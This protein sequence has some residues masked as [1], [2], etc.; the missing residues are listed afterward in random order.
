MFVS[1]TVENHHLAEGGDTIRHGGPG[2]NLGQAIEII[3]P[4]PHT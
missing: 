3:V 2:K 4:Y 1:G